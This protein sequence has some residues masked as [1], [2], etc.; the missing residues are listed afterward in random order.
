MTAK[1]NINNVIVRV[2]CLLL[3]PNDCGKLIE[4]EDGKAEISPDGVNEICSCN[5]K[6]HELDSK[7]ESSR[8]TL[9]LVWY[10]PPKRP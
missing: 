1:E 3:V 2:V 10:R 7:Y 4:L 6:C 9:S 5:F 8:V